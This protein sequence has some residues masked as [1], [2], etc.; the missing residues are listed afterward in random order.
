M[1]V[2]SITNLTSLHI[3]YGNMFAKLASP[4]ASGTTT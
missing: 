1:V 4:E 3:P 2:K